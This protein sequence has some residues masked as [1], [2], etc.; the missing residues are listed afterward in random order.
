[1]N[2]GALS[3]M[4]LAVTSLHEIA[5]MRPGPKLREVL[6]ERAK[7]LADVLAVIESCRDRDG[8]LNDTGRVLEWTLLK[9]RQWRAW[10]MTE[11]ADDALAAAQSIAFNFKAAADSL[12]MAGR[13]PVTAY[14]R[15]PRCRV[16]P[17]R[18]GGES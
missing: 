2:N 17:A 8:T 5:D 7:S 1:M 10:G 13:V 9:E 6:R 14:G 16:S 18:I 4:D 11:C 12:R 3:A 15:A